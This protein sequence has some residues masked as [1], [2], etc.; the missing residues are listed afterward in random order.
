MRYLSSRATPLALLSF[1]LTSVTAFAQ[2]NS[3]SVRAAAAAAE[4]DRFNMTMSATVNMSAAQSRAREFSLTYAGLHGFWSENELTKKEKLLLAV[5]AEIL[6][7]HEA[8]LRQP[9][10]GLCK[11]LNFKSELIDAKELQEQPAFPPLRG[12]GTYFSFV[13]Q[14]HAADEWAQL[15][16][17]KG[18]FLPG[19]SV[20]K[21]GANNPRSNTNA[22]NITSGYALTVFTPLGDV[23]LEQVTDETPAVALLNQYTPPTQM[24]DFARETEKFLQGIQ[25][26]GTAFSTGVLTRVDQTYA[27]RSVLYKKADIVI[28]FRVVRE[29]TDG[30]LYLLW[31]EIKNFPVPKLEGKAR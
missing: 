16:I 17:Y 31:K 3:D 26:S 13:K 24:A 4:A 27:M 10:T 28:A 22:F 6:Q 23:P 19:Y 7:K 21:R 8:F 15:R 11:L 9:K 14:S 20:F 18:A 12:A 30:S 1:V 5:E 2:A 25:V 29:A